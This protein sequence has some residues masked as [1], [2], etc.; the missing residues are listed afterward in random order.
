MTTDDS[1]RKKALFDKVNFTTLG[2]ESDYE[3]LFQNPEIH[4]LYLQIDKKLTKLVLLMEE[5]LDI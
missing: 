5:E 3:R 2:V 1:K 4:K